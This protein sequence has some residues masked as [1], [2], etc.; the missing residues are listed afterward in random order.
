[1]F[2][3]YLLIIATLL[4]LITPIWAQTDDS[5]ATRRGVGVVLSGGGAKGLYH[6]GV[7]EALE[8]AGV[9]ID[10]IA[11][12]SMGSIIGAMYAAGYSPAEMRAIVNSGAIQQWVSGRIDATQYL[13]YYRQVEDSPSFINLW[14]DLGAKDNKFQMP[15]NLLSSTQID[16][17]LIELFAAP[18]T[19]AEDDFS[20]LMVPFLCVAADMNKRQPVVF[21]RGSLPEAIRASMSIPLAFKPVK[22]DSML[23][24]DGGIYDNFPW[25][26]LDAKHNPELLIG[27]ICTSGEIRPDGDESLIDQ[28]VLIAMGGSDYTLPKGRSVTIHRAVE[29][30]MLDFDEAEPV[31][32]QGYE[33]TKAQI[34]EILAYIPASERWCAEQYSERREAFRKKCPALIFNDYKITGLN[35]DQ[36][37]YVR[38]YMRADLHGDNRQRQM[39]FTTLRDNTYKVLVTGDYQMDIPRVEYDEESE[40]YRFMANL[41]ARPKFRFT[42]GGNI[43]STAFNQAYLGIS[44]RSFARVANSVGAHLYLGPTYTWGTLGGRMDFYMN[45]PFFL[46]YAYNFSVENYRHGSF[47]RITEISNT[48][49]V[50]QSESFGS[51]GLGFRL[52]HRSLVELKLHA[53]HA[54]HHNEAVTGYDKLDHTRFWYYGA[55]LELA[56]NTLD[57]YLYPTRGSDLHLSAIYV[58]GRDRFCPEDHGSFNPGVGRDWYGARFQYEKIFNMPRTDWFM[59][60]VNLDAVYTNH[61]RFTSEGATLMTLPAYEPMPHVR[62]IF[63]PDFVAKRFVAGG[64]NPTFSFS[65]NFFLRTGFYAMYRSR[66]HFDEGHLVD[67]EDKQLHFISE[68]AL[69]YHT[70]IGPVNL[71]LIKY[72]LDSWQDMYLMFNFGYPIFAPKGTFY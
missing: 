24:Y 8:E 9:P 11:G 69:V 37:E 41:T 3:T 40:R 47:G 52:T 25:R 16:M 18:S 33:D 43:S 26:Q 65:P 29:V 32:N 4:G 63:M 28:A 6:I 12:T 50:K 45:D 49:P 59:L 57:K 2:R 20:Q 70:P 39:L 62:K 61:P 19:V 66:N 10:Y 1:M 58:S 44:Y 35:S 23:L 55:K 31:M 21:D 22:R 51:L 17:A 71:S 27:S 34:E 15:R 36:Q 60:G 64:V 53:G 42:I 5:T 30:G 48:L 54:N 56:R 67:W 72:D 38:D 7:L 13:P 46:T 68:M 14:L